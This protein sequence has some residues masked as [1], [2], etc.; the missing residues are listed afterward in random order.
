MLAVLCPK[1]C[2]FCSEFHS[3]VHW[4]AS[5]LTSISTGKD[6]GLCVNPFNV[7]NQHSLHTPHRAIPE[8]WR[9][10]KGW[11]MDQQM[12]EW[13]ASRCKHSRPPW[14]GHVLGATSALSTFLSR[15]QPKSPWGPQEW[16]LSW[17]PP[18]Q[19]YWRKVQGR[20]QCVMSMMWRKK[21]EMSGTNASPP[22]FDGLKKDEYYLI[23]YNML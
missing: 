23:F 11:Q 20:S 19:S 2:P 5:L 17:P 14:V 9:P 7:L 16:P 10:W 22:C 8:E 15:R 13:S 4:L 1:F 21:W 12:I 6:T 18:F 3:T